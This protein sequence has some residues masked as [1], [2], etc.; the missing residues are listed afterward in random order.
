[1]NFGLPQIALARAAFH[2]GV[3]FIAEVKRQKAAGTWDPMTAHYAGEGA[4]KYVG[5]IATG[6]LA[7]KDV[8]A[9]RQNERCRSCPF[10]VPH[11]EHPNRLGTCGPAFVDRMKE[12]DPTCGCPIEVMT[13][14]ASHPCPQHKFPAVPKVGSGSACSIR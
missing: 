14:V 6:D 4:K 10:R 2:G 13:M 1:M 5:A 3:E 8:I 12:V 9:F 11:P 7:P